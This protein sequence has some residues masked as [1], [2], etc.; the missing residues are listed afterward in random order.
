[1]QPSEDEARLSLS[2]REIYQNKQT[3]DPKGQEWDS[4]INSDAS[5]PQVSTEK[6]SFKSPCLLLGLFEANL[7]LDL[8]NLL[9]CRCWLWTLELIRGSQ[10]VHQASRLPLASAAP[11]RPYRTPHPPFPEFTVRM[12]EAAPPPRHCRPL[13]RLYTSHD[14]TAG[15][16]MLRLHWTTLWYS[17]C[18]THYPELPS[19]KYVFI[20]NNIYTRDIDFR[21]KCLFNL[22]YLHLFMELKIWIFYIQFL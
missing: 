3:V 1:M 5:S 22:D 16:R 14:R 2:L 15:N 21:E 12:K 4:L 7:D 8:L 18:K 11:P 9:W 19:T 10:S 20:Q 13:A 6:G 17:H